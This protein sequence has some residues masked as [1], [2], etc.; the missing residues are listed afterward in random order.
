MVGSEVPIP[1][2]ATENEDALAVTPP[3]NL[4]ATLA[5]FRA[6]FHAQG[7]DEAFT[8]VIAVVVQ[9]GVEFA[10][11]TIIIYD[12]AKARLLTDHAKTLSSYNFV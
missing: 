3:E 2:G 5:A 10:D 1:G 6:A 7:L 4:D 11:N 8:R 9:P 12:P